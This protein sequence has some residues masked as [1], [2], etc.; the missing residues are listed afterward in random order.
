VK[1]ESHVENEEMRFTLLKHELKDVKHTNFMQGKCPLI[2]NA[3]ALRIL[4]T[5]PIELTCKYGSKTQNHR[6]NLQGLD[7]SPIKHAL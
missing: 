6:E 7:Q 2:S 3:P 1:L 5:S 4:M